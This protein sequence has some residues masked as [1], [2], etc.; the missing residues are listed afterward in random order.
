MLS[1]QCHPPCSFF[2]VVDTI[3]DSILWIN[4]LWPS[5]AIWRHRSRS[6]LAQVMACSAI[7]STNAEFPLVRFCDIHLRAIS[8]R[9]LKLFSLVSLKII[10][11]K[12]IS[13][14]PR[15]QWVK[16][17]THWINGSNCHQVNVGSGNGLVLSG[18]KP[19]PDL[20]MVEEYETIW[21]R[22]TTMSFN[23]I[24]SQSYSV[25]F[26]VSYSVP[27]FFFYQQPWY[28]ACSISR[29]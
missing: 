9:M 7:T 10:L 19:L 20:V 29:S 12:I 14:N 18:N 22:S 28:W 17:F 1:A 24:V 6:T 16:F 2:K 4:L 27:W 8:K 21:S 15:G 11:L 5:D 13:T 23:P 3:F 26:S 25:S